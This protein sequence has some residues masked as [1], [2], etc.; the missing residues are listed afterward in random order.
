MGVIGLGQIGIQH[1]AIL[2]VLT[3]TKVCVAE[4]N[5]RLLKAVSDIGGSICPHDSVHDLLREDLLNGIFVCTP[6]QTHFDVVADILRETHDDLYLFVEKPLATNYRQ[7]SDLINMIGSKRGS[8]VGF[9]K[10]F[11]GIYSRLKRVVTE[12]LLGEIKFYKAHSFS[13][14]VVT[15][16]K[17]WKFEPPDGGVTLDFGTHMMDLILWLFGEAKV[18]SAFKRSIYSRRVE[19]FVHAILSHGNIEGTLDIGWSMRNYS[20]NEHR[21]EIHGTNGSA[22]ATDDRLVLHVDH[23]IEGIIGSGTHVFHST[24]LGVEVPFLL[25]Y[26]EYVLEDEYFLMGAKQRAK[27][28]P[29]FSQGANV[30]QLADSIKTISA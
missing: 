4:K 9:Q 26:P 27:L 17:G 20:P 8:M 3:E 14:D 16:S 22:I 24:D 11:S 15:N 10:R 5:E 28:Q 7:A 2:S 30:N 29:D 13:Y 25:S 6:V 23:S 1:A 18:S 19:D 12:N 21:L